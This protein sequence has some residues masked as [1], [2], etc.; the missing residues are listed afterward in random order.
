VTVRT[1]TAGMPPVVLTP[2]M[3]LRLEAVSP[4]TGA[5]IGGVNASQWAI[6]GD[7]LE[8]DLELEEPDVPAWVWKDTS[9]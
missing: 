3:I 8:G 9:V 4:T 7:P 2:G 1:L 5:A 6:Y